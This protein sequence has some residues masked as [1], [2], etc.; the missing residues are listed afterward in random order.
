MQ[1]WDV[2][3]VEQHVG[4]DVRWLDP[5]AGERD[6]DDRERRDRPLVRQFDELIENLASGWICLAGR[7]IQ[8]SGLACA[9]AEQLAFLER[10]QIR[11]LGK[12][13]GVLDSDAAR[14]DLNGHRLA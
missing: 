13:S 5:L 14:R 9:P 1:E 12:R 2:G 11:R 6:V 3:P 4:S 10:L 8:L 7:E